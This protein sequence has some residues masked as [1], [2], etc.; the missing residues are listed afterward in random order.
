MVL[1]SAVAE[2]SEPDAGR[3]GLC[4]ADRPSAIQQ[5]ALVECLAP[6][7]DELGLCSEHRKEL[8]SGE[9]GSDGQGPGA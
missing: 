2:S 6:A 8:V 9:R 3:F 7:A 5:S 4:W 1:P